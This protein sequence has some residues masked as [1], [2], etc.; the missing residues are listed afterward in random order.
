M[1]LFKVSNKRLIPSKGQCI[2]AGIT[3]EIQFNGSVL[4]LVNSS[5]KTELARHS[6]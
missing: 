4:P 5:V 6:K 2:E 3:A 1:V